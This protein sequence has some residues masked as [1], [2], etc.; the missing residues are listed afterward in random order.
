M[1]VPRGVKI[2]DRY[3]DRVTLGSALAGRVFR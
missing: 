3:R 1:T 2:T